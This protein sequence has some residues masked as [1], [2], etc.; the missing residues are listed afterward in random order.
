LAI[1]TAS[2]G[3][4]TPDWH[5]LSERVLITLILGIAGEVVV[6]IAAVT[7]LALRNEKSST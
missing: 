6:S 1:D 4:R 5:F 7:F 2:G 3:A